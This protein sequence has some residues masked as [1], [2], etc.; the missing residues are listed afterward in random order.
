MR[1]KDNGKDNNERETKRA[2]NQCKCVEK[3]QK[4]ER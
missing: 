4:G 1:I 2:M 3:K